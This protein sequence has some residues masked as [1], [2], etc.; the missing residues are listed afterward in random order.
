MKVLTKLLSIV[1]CTFFLDFGTKKKN[2]VDTHYLSFKSLEHFS[3]SNILQAFLDGI[4]KL[5]LSALSRVFVDGQAT[6]W[7][8]FQSQIMLFRV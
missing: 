6:N 4:Y 3:A 1:K 8:F 2:S 7:K 5:N